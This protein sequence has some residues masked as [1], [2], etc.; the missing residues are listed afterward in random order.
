MWEFEGMRVRSEFVV[1]VSLSLCVMLAVFET[2]SEEV[3][4]CGEVVIYRCGR[5]RKAEVVPW[6][7]V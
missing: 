3:R 4:R 1:Y 5:Y 7:W 6:A 2:E